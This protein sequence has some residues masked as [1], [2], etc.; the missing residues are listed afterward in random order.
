[1]KS[2]N[3]GCNFLN[4]YLS[5]N[6]FVVDTKNYPGPSAKLTQLFGF[7]NFKPKI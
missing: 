7:T 4:M 3:K 1:M 5:S 6:S 2:V